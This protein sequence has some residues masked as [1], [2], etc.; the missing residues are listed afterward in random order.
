MDMCTY[1]Y[2]FSM[3]VYLYLNLCSC[4]HSGSRGSGCLFSILCLVSMMCI[5]YFIALWC[6]A[7]SIFLSHFF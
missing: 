2:A 5:R 6:R 7:F 4:I 3:S 1:S